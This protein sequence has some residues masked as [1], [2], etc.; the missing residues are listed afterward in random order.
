MGCAS[1]RESDGIEASRRWTADTLSLSGIM[2]PRGSD[3]SRASAGSSVSAPTG[4]CL[5]A[6]VDKKT[7][8]RKRRSG[9]KAAMFGG[10]GGV[11]IGGAGR[12]RLQ[13]LRSE[14]VQSC[15]RSPDCVPSG[16]SGATPA[17]CLKTS[18]SVSDSPK[19]VTFPVTLTKS[20]RECQTNTPVFRVYSVLPKILEFVPFVSV[21]SFLGVHPSWRNNCLQCGFFAERGDQ[22]R[23]PVWRAIVRRYCQAHNLPFPS[24]W[25]TM[26]CYGFVLQAR[27]GRGPPGVS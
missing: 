10:G 6:P 24:L 12:A 18:S 21:P 20:Q 1:G 11:L 13:G 27:W 23:L 19:L 26:E 2:L 22:S 25:S 9:G 3:C 5:E 16:S 8:R 15:I 14:R 17:S 4:F 7:V